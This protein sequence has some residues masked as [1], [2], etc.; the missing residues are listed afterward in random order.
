V[1]AVSAAFQTALTAGTVRPR[2]F[3]GFDTASTTYRYWTGARDITFL[4]ATWYGNSV[5]QG[6]DAYK[7]SEEL[8]AEGMSVTL[9][10]ESEAL[11]S[12]IL[13][14]V[15]QGKLG[16]LWFALLDNNEALIA[17]P[18]QIFSGRLD[19]AELNDDPNRASIKLYFES[20]LIDLE[21][22][23]EF[24][25]NHE[26]QRAFYGDDLGMEYIDQLTKGW[27]QW[28]GKPQRI[29]RRRK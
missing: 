20:K 21:R 28:W 12:L 6:F 16:G 25:Y 9:A 5:L 18:H 14:D 10:G 7:E 26:T 8:S 2:F 29:Q 4:G 1:R 17:D 27:S 15:R 22:K 13:Q 23:K 3:F 19:R 24:R 11:I